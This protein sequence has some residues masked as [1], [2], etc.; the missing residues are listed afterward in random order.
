MKVDLL[1]TI[2]TLSGLVFF[3]FSLA[4]IFFGKRVGESKGGLQKIK[5]A[6]YVEINTN[7]VLTLVIIT[8]CFSLAPLVIFTWK[9]D[10][11]QYVSKDDLENSYILKKEVDAHYISRAD[12]S[13]AVHGS[14]QFE[15][16]IPASQVKYTIARGESG[17]DVIKT[18]TTDIQGLFYINLDKPNPSEKYTITWEKDG[19]YSAR[20]SFELNRYP[21]AQILRKER[22][23]L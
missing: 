8:A 16:G 19:Y 3:A 1:G 11:A 21:I 10:P 17:S 2:I 20:R 13:L 18:D 6:K 22:E 9:V 5:I 23:Q 4:I 14:L 7:S 12:L 15:S